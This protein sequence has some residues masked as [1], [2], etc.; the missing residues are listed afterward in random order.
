M[1]LREIPQTDPRVALGL[2]LASCCGPDSPTGSE[3]ELIN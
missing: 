3:E 2:P 1:W